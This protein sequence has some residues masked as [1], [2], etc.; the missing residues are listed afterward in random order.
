ML[1]LHDKLLNVPIMSLQTGAELARTDAP[2]IDP[3]TLA[4]I[5]FFVDGPQLDERPSVLH[6]SDIREAG[7]LGFIVDDAHALMPLDGLVR[8]EQVLDFDF[9]LIGSK[10]EDT[11]GRHIG[12]VADYAFEPESFV[13]QQLYI[14][15]SFFKSLTAASHIIHRSQIVAIKPDKIVVEAPTIA[16]KAV[17]TAQQA[18]ALV[19]PFRSAPQPEPI[20]AAKQS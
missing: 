20:R 15:Q 12:A 1:L 4:V 18:R 7:S 9:T 6:V 13:I 11:T 17:K 19:N 10:V 5:A 3:R 2:I 16:D 8:L 14:Q